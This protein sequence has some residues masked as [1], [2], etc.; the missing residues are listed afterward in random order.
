MRWVLVG[1][2]DF[3]VLVKIV[4][5][6]GAPE[7]G[8]TEASIDLAY[9]RVETDN[10]VTT[11]DV[12]P[13]SL[14]NLTA[15]HSDWGF[16][17]VSSTDHPGLYRLDLADA[18]FAPGAWEAVVTIT[19]AS[20][21]DFYPVDIGF[22]LVSVNLDDSVRFGLS[23]LPNAAFG[24]AGS[25]AGR[26]DLQTVL[27]RLTAGRATNLD[28]LDAAMSTR[29]PAAT[30]LSTAQ[31]TNARA[32]LLDNLSNL[33]AAISSLNNLSALANL[34]GSP[35][36]EIPDAGT[37]QFAF[38][39]VVRDN[40]GKLKDLDGNPT[41][42]AANAAGA[43]RSANLSVISHPSTGRYTFTYGV[44]SAAAEESLRITCS[45]TVSAEARYIE[46]I[47]AVVNYDT[48][49]TLAAT[50]SGVDSIVAKLPANSMTDSDKLLAFVQLLTRND[51]ALSTDRAAELAEINQD[52][53]SGTGNYFPFQE[54]LQVLQ[55]IAG[56]VSAI[57][58]DTG[59]LD[60]VKLHSQYDLYHADIQFTVDEANSRD[61]YTVTWLK[62]GVRVSAG[63]TG[64][65]IQVV[66][67]ADGTDLIAS[68]AMSQIG[69]TGSYKFDEAA[70][71]VTGGEAVLVLVGATIDGSARTFPRL[72]ARDSAA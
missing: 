6:D 55:G 58:N 34:Y 15:A 57:L 52:Q 68:Q 32:A 48:L 51:V 49:T 17:E 5:T 36:L 11:S 39:L 30:A 25:V 44:S 71:R 50:K 41:I 22:R 56:N 63:I 33:D 19:D 69:A 2:T 3:T 37:T 13:A 16:I 59:G 7:T 12:T 4:G 65:T 1:Q 10:D 46:W 40:E 9:S 66:K 20:G 64:P 18:V 29:A 24:A 14:A 21:T 38:T 26:D 35:L 28:N 47:G 31:W 60:G 45:G 27:G 23:A 70:N 8:L 61:E 62:N 54:A 67:R 43:D 42:T 53:G 72:V